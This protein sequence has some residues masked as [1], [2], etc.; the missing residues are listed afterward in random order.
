[1][2]AVGASA[3][4]ARGGALVPA[5]EACRHAR[6]EI[7]WHRSRLSRPARWHLLGQ[8]GATVW[9]TGL[10]ASG[11]STIGA[12]LE[13][14]IAQSGHM[15]YMLDG[16]NLRHG[17]SSD[18][19][20]CP[21]DRRENVRRV[22]HVARLFADAGAIAIVSLISPYVADRE[23]ARQVHAE[24]EVEFLEVFVNTPLEECERRDPKGLY[25]RA[26]RGEIAEFTGVDADYEAPRAPDLELLPAEHDLGQLV[27][28]VLAKLEKRGVLSGCGHDGVGET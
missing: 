19:G 11:K 12:A 7:T 13:E 2:G 28:A 3:P 16:D 4:P 18:L 6:A 21:D 24:G 27:G 14:R 10:P 15:A 8:R 9:L 1:M 20:F 26:R 5:P 25:A 22:A 17:L 23:A